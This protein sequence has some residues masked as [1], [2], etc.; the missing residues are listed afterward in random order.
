[1][2]EHF[3]PEESEAALRHVAEIARRQGMLAG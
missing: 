3:G 2:V 1:M